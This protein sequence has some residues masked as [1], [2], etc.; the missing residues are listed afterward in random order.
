[1]IMKTSNEIKAF[2]IDTMQ[3]HFIE[4]QKERLGLNKQ[5]DRP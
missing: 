1:M 5:E 2:I 3:H 4:K